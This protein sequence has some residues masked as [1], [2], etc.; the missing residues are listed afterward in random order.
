MDHRAWT[1][2][3]IS[4]GTILIMTHTGMAHTVFFMHPPHLHRLLS[5]W[6]SRASFA[7]RRGIFELRCSM[8]NSQSSHLYANASGKDVLRVF[9]ADYRGESASKSRSSG[10]TEVE[11][12]VGR[13]LGVFCVQASSSGVSSEIS[14]RVLGRHQDRLGFDLADNPSATSHS[15]GNYRARS[16]N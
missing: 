11:F 5:G 15:E 16:Y 8:A 1:N 13:V 4:T 6:L 3:R 7:P 9:T 14:A 10:E 12:E 2:D